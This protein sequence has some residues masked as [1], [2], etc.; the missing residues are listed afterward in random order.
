VRC[1]QDILRALSAWTRAL[2]Q[3]TVVSLLQPAPAVFQLFDEV[4]PELSRL[5]GSRQGELLCLGVTPR[6]RTMLVLR[7][8]S[9]SRGRQLTQVLDPGSHSFLRCPFQVVVL[10]QG[11]V[12][13]AGPA[14]SA[15]SYF[16]KM[17]FR[18]VP[19]VDVADFLVQ[20]TI[21]GGTKKLLGHPRDQ[22][23]GVTHRIPNDTWCRIENQRHC[24]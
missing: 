5:A 17:G 24:D 8:I 14:S 12:C 15:E 19:E 1:L 18:R 4:R 2:G 21:P 13:Y 6:H 9:S 23:S 11:H 7:I 3:T 10:K 16:I 20:L 22:V